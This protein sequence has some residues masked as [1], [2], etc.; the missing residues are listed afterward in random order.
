MSL[1]AAIYLR[2]S[3][4]GQAETGSSL[5]SQ[6]EACL[7]YASACGYNVSDRIFIERGYTGTKLD[8]PELNRLLDYVQKEQIDVLI[9]WKLDRFSRDDT[10]QGMIYY[11]LDQAGVRLESVVEGR[12]E[13][14]PIGHFMRHVYGYVAEQEHHDI[15]KRTSRG[16]RKRAENGRFPSGHRARL[17]GYTYV[18]GRGPGEGVRYIN[19]AQACW[20]KRIFDWYLY[21]NLGLDK[22][23]ARL[24]DYNVISPTGRPAWY[25]SSVAYMLKNPAY[26]GETYVYCR[27]KKQ[28]KKSNTLRPKEEWLPIPGATPPIIDRT[29]WEAVQAKMKQNKAKSE[30]NK[31]YEYLLAGHIV[32]GKCGRSYWAY[33][34]R[35]RRRYQCSGKCGRITPTRCDNQNWD[36][37]KLESMVWRDL[38][39]ALSDPRIIT[40]EAEYKANRQRQL[41]SLKPN[42]ADIKKRLVALDKDQ[43]A[44]LQWALKGFP[45]ATIIK[46]NDRINGMRE[47]LKK[48]Q[49]ELEASIEALGQSMIDMEGV[50]VVCRLL[51]EKN[52]RLS[53][54]KREI[55]ELLRITVTVTGDKY[56]IRGSV[57][58]EYGHIASN[59]LPSSG[60]S[61][62]SLPFLIES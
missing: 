8:R 51:K 53:D 60:H 52:S 22:I 1:K 44:L 2:V 9:V 6:E 56:S 55:I 23:C 36:A 26:V 33:L 62:P 15:F 14:T 43:D 32:C 16:L 21:D 42:L 17:Y 27:T 18:P 37:D 57:P 3:T 59:L 41:N 12:L 20:V 13:N 45:E 34:K 5:E 50:R 48:Q 19:E 35:K 61:R 24:K 31:K 30:R 46:E 49:A 40:S 10:V 25:R 47:S 58:P 11:M 4:P 38:D 7:Q 28:G 29:V 54:V 39:A